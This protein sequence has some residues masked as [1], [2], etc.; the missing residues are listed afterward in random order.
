MFSIWSRDSSL[1]PFNYPHPWLLSGAKDNVR[2][3]LF[4]A[5]LT[6]IKICFRKQLFAIEH[7]GRLDSTFDAYSGGLEFKP[8]PG[9]RLFGLRFSMVLVHPFKIMR[10]FIWKQW[11]VT[12]RRGPEGR[13]SCFA[14]GSLGIKHQSR[15]RLSNLK[16]IVV[17]L[18]CSRKVPWY[19]PT[20]GHNS[21]LLGHFQFLIR[22]APHLS[23]LQCLK[24]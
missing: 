17:C 16:V 18:S 22:Q 9:K 2:K 4:V 1:S 15:N 20:V 12:V 14:V 23:K 3:Q 8:R 21:F 24:Y 5:V 11:P 10:V 6:R 7:R 13:I 19:C